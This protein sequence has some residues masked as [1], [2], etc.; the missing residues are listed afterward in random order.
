MVTI[1]A[2]LATGGVCAMATGWCMVVIFAPLRDWL[3]GWPSLIAGG[4]SNAGM[5]L[6]LSA[7]TLLVASLFVAWPAFL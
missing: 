1:H 2:C 5:I 3:D 7:V 6:M 4:I